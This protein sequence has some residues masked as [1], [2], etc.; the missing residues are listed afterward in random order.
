MTENEI[1]KLIRDRGCVRSDFFND[2]EQITISK[3]TNEDKITCSFSDG[4]TLYKIT[5]TGKQALKDSS[6]DN[7]RWWVT[8][9]IAVLSLFLSVISLLR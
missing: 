4:V 3:L 2:E 8:T 5:P 7:A 6:S 1:L 9:V